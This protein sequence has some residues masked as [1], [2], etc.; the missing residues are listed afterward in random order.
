MQCTGIALSLSFLLCFSSLTPTLFWSKLS[1]NY[2]ASQMPIF[3]FYQ[4]VFFSCV[5]MCF[6]FP[7][8]QH[9]L[10]F[11]IFKL[12]LL[13]CSCYS[14]PFIL[15]V[16]ARNRIACQISLY[17]FFLYFVDQLMFVNPKCILL[18][19]FYDLGDISFYILLIYII[20]SSLL[21]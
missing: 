17:Y 12:Q 6:T 19:D 13:F 10:A 15:I 7:Y 21:S 11:M 2:K 18:L 14:L 8:P 9:C 20:F 4:N 1:L 5:C 16:I 3:L